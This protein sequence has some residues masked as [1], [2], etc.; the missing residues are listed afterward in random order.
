MALAKAEIPLT[1]GQLEQFERDGYLILDDLDFGD[2]LLDGIVSDLSGLYEGEVRVVDD[3][4][5]APHRIAGAWKVNDRVRALALNPSVLA[6]VEQLFGRVPRPFETLNFRVGT[7][8]PTHSDTIHFNSMPRGY[9]CGVWVALEDIDMENGPVVYYPGSHKLPE[10]TLKDVGP[11]A[12]EEA[13]HAHLAEV[14]ERLELEPKY[15]T[16]EKGQAFIWAS[17][18]LHGG[19]PQRDRSRTRFSQVTQYFFEDCRYWSPLH[20]R[21]DDVHWLH[22]VWITDDL[23]SAEEAGRVRELVELH[24]PDGSTVLV[25][26]RGDEEMVKLGDRDGWHFPRDESGV[27]PGYYP[28]DGAEAVAHL[29]DLIAK[30]AG[31][32]VLPESALWWLDHYGELADYLERRCSRLTGDDAGCLIFALPKT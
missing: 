26:S 3:V 1:K 7:E 24:V 17:N 10:V 8:Q 13:Y 11:D 21:G 15:A 22:P 18:L 25:A 27:W 5:Y 19:S 14:I 30:G 2:R 32:L 29:E 4:F 23:S 31:Y 9:M 28:A 20:S 6:V 16:I 12:G